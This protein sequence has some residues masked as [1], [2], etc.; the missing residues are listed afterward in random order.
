[1]KKMV[2]YLCVGVVALGLSA[3]SGTKPEDGSKDSSQESTVEDGSQESSVEDSSQ[4]S[5]VEDSQESGSVEDDQVLDTSAGWSEEMQGLKDAVKQ[6]VGEENYWPDMAVDTE[7]LQMFYGITS[8]MYDDYMAET[9]MISNNVDALV[10]IKAKEDKVDAVEE[11]LNA[12]R[13]AKVND[14]MQYPANLGKIQASQVEKIG[15]YVIF[16]Q[17]GGFAVD[18][19]TEEESLAQCQEANKLALDTIREKLN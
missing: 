6:A 10:I 7:M 1:M 3:C 12:Y 13:E 8:D 19:E 5:S 18:A 17:L 9:P 4:E 11:A 2:L 16:V 15:S 14:T